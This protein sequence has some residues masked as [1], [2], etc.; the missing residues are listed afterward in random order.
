M[1]AQEL[2]V[3][4]NCGRRTPVYRNRFPFFCSCGVVHES[5]DGGE[6]VPRPARP[7]IVR[8]IANV[9]AATV[10]HIRTGGRTLADDEREARMDVCK[11]CQRFDGAVCT[12]PSCGCPMN[13]QQNAF[14]SAIAW[15]EYN[16]PEGKWPAVKTHE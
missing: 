11:T 16:C 14:L 12:H 15:S 3:C 9:A 5:S 2:F 4:S 7:S 13:P 10:E 6:W 8:R 1:S